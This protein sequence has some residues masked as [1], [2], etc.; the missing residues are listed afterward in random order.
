MFICVGMQTTEEEVDNEKNL[1]PM[2]PIDVD[3]IKTEC[4]DSKSNVI[5][6]DLLDDEVSVQGPAKLNNEYYKYAYFYNVAILNLYVSTY[7]EI[8]DSSDNEPASSNQ[9][10]SLSPPP[11]SPLTPDRKY[12]E[13]HAK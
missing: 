9:S 3:Q 1:D 8:V 2:K 4:N 5:D 11:V 7:I 6:V 13:L 12:L 10:I